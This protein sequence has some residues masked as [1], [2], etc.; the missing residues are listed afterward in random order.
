LQDAEFDA[1]NPEHQMMRLYVGLEEA[2]YLT[3]DLEQAFNQAGWK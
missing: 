1:S 3:G 2:A